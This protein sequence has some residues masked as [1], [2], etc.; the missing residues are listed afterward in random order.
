MTMTKTET[1]LT[2]RYRIELDTTADVVEFN[3]IASK[4]KG[5]VLL[6][7]EDMKLNAKSFIGVH[8]ARIAWDELYVES[9]VDCY[10]DFEKF[11][12]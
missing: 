2:Y 1:R 10:H 5:D 9:N 11:I 6:V 7:G 8:M 3:R 4:I 12:I